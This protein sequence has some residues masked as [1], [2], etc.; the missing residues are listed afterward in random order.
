MKICFI[1][2]TSLLNSEIFSG[3]KKISVKNKFGKV[4]L[5]RHKDIFFIQRHEGGLPPHALNYKGYIQAISDL[6]VQRIISLNSSG[7]LKRSLRVPSIMIPDDFIGFW[8]IPTFFD[9]EIFHITPKFSENIRRD[10]IRTAKELKISVRARGVYFQTTG[11]RLETPA[12][13]RMMSK[14]ADVV[15]MTLASEM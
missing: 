6:G 14:F 11:P 10:I 7:A 3:F 9:S 8:N 12:E 15:G 4:S 5:Y 1:G 2:G 13:I